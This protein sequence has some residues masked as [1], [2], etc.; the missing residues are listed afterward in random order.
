MAREVGDEVDPQPVVLF[1][2]VCNLCNAIVNFILDHEADH[3]LKFSPLQSEYAKRAVGACAIPGGSDSVVLVEG[4][5][6]YT[7]SEAAL[8]ITRH[9]K[10]PW[11]W[12]AILL[13]I[14]RPVREGIYHFISRH[15]YQWFGKRAQCRVPEPGLKARFLE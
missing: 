4:G 3:R 9:L 15:R 11:R 13:W 1:D 5:K 6:C 12:A 8:R 10:R 7:A 14:P 2:G